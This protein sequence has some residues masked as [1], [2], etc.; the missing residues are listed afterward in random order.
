MRIPRLIAVVLA[1]GAIA[2]AAQD[3]H[4]QQNQGTLHSLIEAL[5]AEDTVGVQ[6]HLA[7]DFTLTFTGGTTVTGTEAVHMLMLLDTPIT[8][9]SGTPGGMQKGTAEINF[10]SG[11]PTYT[12]S[13][14]GARG[15]KFASITIEAPATPE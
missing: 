3:A 2:L 4:A 15:G 14:T 13:Y 1:A 5:N 11:T 6:A 9:V 7:S 8:L 12:L 10:G